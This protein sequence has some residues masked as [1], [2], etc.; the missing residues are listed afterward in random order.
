M[1]PQALT[2]PLCR[3]QP[4][5]CQPDQ[6]GQLWEVDTAAERAQLV[7]GRCLDLVHLSGEAGSAG[8]IT[9]AA[10]T[11]CPYQPLRQV[12][13]ANTAQTPLLSCTGFTLCDEALCR[14][15]QNRGAVAVL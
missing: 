14:L 13:R 6:R 11:C 4:L 5:D 9:A 8:L 1:L 7:R 2:G 10:F 15:Q 3:T 12:S